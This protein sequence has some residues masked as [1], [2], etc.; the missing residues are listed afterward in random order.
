MRRCALSGCLAVAALLILQLGVRADQAQL[1]KTGPVFSA[2]KG[3]FRIV[4]DGVRVGTEQFDITPDGQAWVARSST[5]LQIPNG[6]EMKAV[7]ELRLAAEGAPLHY[8]WS[9]VAPKAASGSVSFENGTAKCSLTIGTADPFLR[10][11]HF[12]DPHVTVLDNNLYY[13]YAVL[14]RV[15]DWA[16]AG[17][18]DF[19]VVIPQDMIPGTVKVKLA[20]SSGPLS[21]LVV[22]TPD[23]EIHLFCDTNHRMIRLEVPASKVV[24]ERE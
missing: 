18:Q 9:T 19:H 24:V 22:T 23:L 2:D 21:E 17:E 1:K 16:A 15:Y 8:Q 10:D 11:F 6:G 4:L 13:Q 20:G 3:R 5:D 7:G 12:D 14:A